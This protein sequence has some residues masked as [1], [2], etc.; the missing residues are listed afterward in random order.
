MAEDVYDS[1]YIDTMMDNDE[2]SPSEHGIMHWY[3]DD[4]EES[5]N[6]DDNLSQE[7]VNEKQDFP[8]V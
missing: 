2:L 7:N 4:G 3:D 1:D 5:L 6:A 8:V